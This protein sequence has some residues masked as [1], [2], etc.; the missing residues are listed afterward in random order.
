MNVKEAVRTAKDY[1]GDLF[2]E[3]NLSNL[4]L[5]EIERDD[6]A[7]LW[8]VTVGFSRPWNTVKT[9]LTALSG[10]ASPRRA[11]RIVSVNDNGEVIS[12]KRRGFDPN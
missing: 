9:A 6:L 5:E 11:F 10:E 12:I 2:A 1:V 7:G 4:G 3:E 8:K